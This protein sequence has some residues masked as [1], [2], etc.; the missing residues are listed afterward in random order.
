MRLIDALAAKQTSAKGQGRINEKHA[1]ENQP[2]EKID[3]A[4]LGRMEGDYRDH[5]AEEATADVAHENRGG[6]PIPPEESETSGAGNELRSDLDR[7]TLRYEQ[8]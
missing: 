2:S 4:R 5:I 1:P 3:R 8:T 6:R 7:G